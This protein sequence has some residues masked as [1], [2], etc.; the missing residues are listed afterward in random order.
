MGEEECGGGATKNKW[1][2]MGRWVDGWMGGWVDGWMS[3]WVDGWM[4]YVVR[5][6]VT[7]EST[8]GP[9]VSYPMQM[10]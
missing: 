2:W 9:L 1:W 3:R 10:S 4:G 8:L 5:Q 7:K 6:K